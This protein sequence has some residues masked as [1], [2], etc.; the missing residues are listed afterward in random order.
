MTEDDPGDGS[1]IAIGLAALATFALLASIMV[2]KPASTSSASSTSP[3]TTPT[4]TQPASAPPVVSSSTGP[5]LSATTTTSV[6]S[7]S[8]P[9]TTVSNDARQSGQP[10]TIAFVG[11][12][13][14]EGLPDGDI[15]GAMASR[16]GPMHDALSAADLTVANLESA[17]TGRGTEA[18]KQFT[19]RAPPE[20]FNGM[21]AAGIDVA[22]MANN[23]GMDYG[24]EGL[25]DSLWA[26]ATSP[27]TVIG[28]GGDEDQAFAPAK[29]TVKGQRVAVIAAT[30]VLDTNLA[31]AATATATQGGLASAKRVDRLVAEVTRSRAESDI[32]VVFLHWGVEK[33]T[34][35]STEQQDLAH[36][37]A[38][39]GADVIVG[40]HAHRVQGGGFL[41]KAFVDYG[42]GN[43]AFK[44]L[45]AEAARSGVL[46]VTAD[47]RGVQGFQ[48][49][50]ALIE[51]ST[52]RPV[53]GPGRQ[54]AIDEWNSLRACAGLADA[55]T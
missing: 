44:A 7:T 38:F 12:S 5:P 4:T 9:P 34:C 27:I 13:N 6:P 55:A 24:A 18:A 2:I 22:S 16:L 19:F 52:P 50:P 25:A 41:G 48:W 31:T 11:D 47:G 33:S 36:A 35:P 28:I 39:A 42:L 21:Q 10:I 54:R 20:I 49:Q 1:R 30:Q 32:V 45:G 3:T 15:A 14:G 40:G 29:V 26:K 46:T 37:L 51:S 53:E 23:H 43:F 8:P 17:V